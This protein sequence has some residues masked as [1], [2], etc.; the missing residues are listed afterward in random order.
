VVTERRK[1]A[2]AEVTLGNIS[3][4]DNQRNEAEMKQ[5]QAFKL[6]HRFLLE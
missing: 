5:I 6:K 1:K 4:D 3:I 2:A